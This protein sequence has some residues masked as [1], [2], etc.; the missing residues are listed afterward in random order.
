ETVADADVETVIEISD[1]PDIKLPRDVLFELDEADLTGEADAFL[2]WLASRIEVFGVLEITVEGLAYNTVITGINEPLSQGRADSV[3]DRVEE[4]V[5]TDIEYTTEGHGSQKPI[6]DNDNE[7]GRALNR[8][9]TIS[10]PTDMI[11]ENNT[12]GE[13]APDQGEG[14]PAS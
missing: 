2:D 9:V 6:A 3:R 5:N 8:R 1:S 12:P 11:T 4:M 13:G 7:E 10:I 14:T